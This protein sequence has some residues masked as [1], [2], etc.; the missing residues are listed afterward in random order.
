MSCYFSYDDLIRHIRD[1]FAK[2]CNNKHI[3]VY[4]V[5]L[6]DCGADILGPCFEMLIRWKPDRNIV[7]IWTY[8]LDPEYQQEYKSGKMS[9]TLMY[10]FGIK[11]TEFIEWLSDEK[12]REITDLTQKYV[13]FFQKWNSWIMHDAIRMDTGT[14]DYEKNIPYEYVKGR[15]DLQTEIELLAI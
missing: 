14:P 6:D 15:K 4:P 10:T 1:R 7:T 13:P 9:R 8:Y 5:C 3:R 12:C 2:I 11:D